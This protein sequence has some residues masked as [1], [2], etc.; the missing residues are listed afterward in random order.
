MN[1]S[2]KAGHLYLFGNLTIVQMSHASKELSTPTS[3]FPS[4]G[5]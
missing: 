2:V 4:H 3:T 1:R 5:S